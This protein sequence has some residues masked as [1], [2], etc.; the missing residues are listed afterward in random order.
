MKKKTLV[1]VTH[2]HIV[3]SVVNKR[4]VEEL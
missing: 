1:I 4:W 2:P 3:H